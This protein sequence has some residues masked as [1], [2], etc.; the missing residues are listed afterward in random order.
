[1]QNVVGWPAVATALGLP[2][3]GGATAQD[4]L[5]PLRA[6]IVGLKEEIFVE[7]PAEAAA[8]GSVESAS[9]AEATATHARRDGGRRLMNPPNGATDPVSILPNR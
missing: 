1:M 8:A 5:D 3:E 4:P 9:A 6:T 2:V 7:L